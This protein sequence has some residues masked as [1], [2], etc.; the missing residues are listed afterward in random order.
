[1][2]EIIRHL[3]AKTREKKYLLTSHAEKEREADTITRQEI[4]ESLLSEECEPIEDYPTDPRGHS[5]LV[6]G[7]TQANLPIHFVCGKLH[8]EE[9]L[10]ITIYR[11]DP[12]RWIN[13]RT[14]KEP[15]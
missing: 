6:L 1:M 13:W 14:R 10:I 7:F 11:P 15:S 4:E 5:C 9:F 2:S 12:T 3:Q 8:E